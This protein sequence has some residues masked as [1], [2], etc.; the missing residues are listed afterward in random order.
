MCRV[1]QRIVF[2]LHKDEQGA[3]LL[4]FAIVVPL[5]VVF[6]VGIYD[7]SLAFNQRQKIVQ[8][9]QEGAIIA[10]AQP[11]NDIE[12]TAAKQDSLVPVVT[13]I[14]NS[15]TAGGIL[16]NANSGTC[17]MPPPTPIAAAPPPFTWQYTISGCSA[18]PYTGSDDLVITIN[19]GWSTGTGPVS[20][21]TSVTVVYPY[22]WRFGSVIQLLFPGPNGYSTPTKVTSTA[23]VHNQI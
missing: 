11:T 12:Q 9:A 23:T 2:Q 18:A 5:L 15:L 16:P 8:A 4:E 10:G 6:V 20:L 13:A 19:R 7:F 1:I 17:K 14:F 3:S 22:H 21:G